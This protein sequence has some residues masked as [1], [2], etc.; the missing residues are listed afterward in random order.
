MVTPKE[1]KL[2]FLKLGGS[3]ITDK[4]TPRTSRQDVIGR[5]ARE[6]KSAREK[7]PGLGL[8]LGH[9]S[10]SYGHTS[11]KKYRT[12]DG[13][14]SQEEWLG[15][16][17]VLFDAASLNNLV[18][19]ELAENGVPAAVFPPSAAV[20]STNRR[21][22]SWDLEPIQSTLE[23][24]LLPVIYGDVVFDT[25][26][27]GTILSTEDLFFYLAR[28]LKP[29]RILLAGQDPGV[30]KDFPEC[31]QLYDRLQPS[32]LAQLGQGVSQ[33]Q[34]PDVTGGMAEK[35]SQMVGLVE[36]LPELECLIFSGEEPGA[37]A[38]AIG[39]DRIG[40]LISR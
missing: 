7:N 20:I 19:S 26:I 15:F 17:E 23:N 30:W 31:T 10:G 4:M 34:A 11:G 22:T 24:G 35:V 33:S 37:V 6:I 36:T 32:D 8:L 21:I 29:S 38:A 40:T 2:I 16:A 28:I 25:D 39:G 9:G 18:M 14:S 3:L 27:G 13:V 12:R 1:T 5:L